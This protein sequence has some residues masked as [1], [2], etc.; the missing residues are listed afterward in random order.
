MLDADYADKRC[1]YSSLAFH[2]HQFV[3]S[4]AAVAEFAQ[5]TQFLPDLSRK[6]VWRLYRVNALGPARKRSA[7]QAR[8]LIQRSEFEPF[9]E[10]LHRAFE[11]L[12]RY[13]TCWFWSDGALLLVIC[14]ICLRSRF[15]FKP[16]GSVFDHPASLRSYAEVNAEASRLHG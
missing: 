13:A 15:K 1:F 6:L 12:R 8:I 9:F 7:S 14:H 2:F 10:R 4:V 11:H 3:H 16:P 5:P